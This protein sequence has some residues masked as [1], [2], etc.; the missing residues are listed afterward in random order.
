MSKIHSK[1]AG[2]MKEESPGVE[3]EQSY[4]LEVVKDKPGN[5]GGI[6]L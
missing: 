4:V 3:L 6:R 2:T 5:K 1:H